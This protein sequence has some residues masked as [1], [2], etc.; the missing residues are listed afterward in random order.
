M[1]ALL[2]NIC[3]SQ[4]MIHKTFLL[5][6][7]CSFVIFLLQC[8]SQNPFVRW[9][10]YPPVIPDMSRG[11]GPDTEGASFDHSLYGEILRDYVY[12]DGLMNYIGLKDKEFKLDA[13]IEKISAVNRSSLSR[14]EDLALLINAYNAFTI[15]LILENPGIY[16]ILDIPAAERWKNERWNIGG[17]K[18]SLYELE[19]DIIRKE[20]TEPRIH[21][22]LVYASRSSPGLI[23]EPY[24]GKNLIEKLEE[25]GIYFF[26]KPENARWDT[27][28][29]ILYLSRIVDWFYT[30]FGSTDSEIVEFILNYV[31]AQIFFHLRLNKNNIKLEYMSYD[32]G[33]NGVWK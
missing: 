12:G 17:R 2:L 14:Y 6:L 16:S 25:Q 24:T 19:H 27:E 20:F 3:V 30:D 31:E 26:S 18:V 22:A 23:N 10:L 4:L 11:L 8:R 13:Y 7:I 21:F 9:M 29:N 33:L 5:Y 15:K 1:R 32:W 28:D